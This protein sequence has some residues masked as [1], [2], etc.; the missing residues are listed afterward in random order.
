M[1]YSSF[2]LSGSNWW[3]TGCG[4]RHADWDL[5]QNPDTGVPRGGGSCDAGHEGGA[6]RGG[7]ETGIYFN[8]CFPLYC[9]LAIVQKI[10]QVYIISCEYKIH[11]HVKF[12]F[13][14]Y[15]WN[16]CKNNISNKSICMNTTQ[17]NF[18]ILVSLHSVNVLKL[19]V[20]I[21]KHIFPEKQVPTI[22]VYMFPPSS[23]QQLALPHRRL[24]CY[25][26]LYE[27][28][29]PNKKEKIGLHQREVFLFNDLLLVGSYYW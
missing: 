27:V 5:Q 6:D 28:H 1:V 2:F 14:N 15:E 4:P 7:E 26:R 18:S 22:C 3:R 9:K 10:E 13:R 12:M 19:H 16:A 21:S 24:V 20:S 8:K 25:C 23:L 29:D 17:Y 11:L